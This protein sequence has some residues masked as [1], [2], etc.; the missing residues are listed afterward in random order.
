M[1]L[2]RRKKV[3]VGDLARSVVL[4]VPPALL[5]AYP[6]PGVPAK[7][8]RDVVTVKS[9][10]ARGRPWHR[11]PRLQARLAPGF[12]VANLRRA[13]G[14]GLA[15]DNKGLTLRLDGLEAG[16]W[17]PDMQDRRKQASTTSDGE[18]FPA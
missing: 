1:A 7:G 11:K 17:T 10:P 5:S 18:L 15:L 3:N 16:A 13:L 9:G 8:D 4:L 12:E 6:D 2:A 14:L